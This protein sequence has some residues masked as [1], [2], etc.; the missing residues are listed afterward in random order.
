MSQPS[1]RSTA[2]DVHVDA[3]GRGVFDE[4]LAAAAVAPGLVDSGMVG[5]DP[6]DQGLAGD[7][8]LHAG[9]GDHDRQEL[10]DGVDACSEAGTL[11]EVMMLCE[12]MTQAV[13][14]SSQPPLATASCTSARSRTSSATGSWATPSTRG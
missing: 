1:V 9:L 13:G 8:V 2:D 6:F 11:V 12:S 10:S 7:R 3:E 5:G 14:S 4:V